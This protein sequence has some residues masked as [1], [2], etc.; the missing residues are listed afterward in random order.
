[1]IQINVGVSLEDFFSLN[2]MPI[3]LET[4]LLIYVI[5]GIHV[6]LLSIIRKSGNQEKEAVLCFCGSRG[7]I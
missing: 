5:C 7:G 6:I 4:L 3:P 2:I 1:M